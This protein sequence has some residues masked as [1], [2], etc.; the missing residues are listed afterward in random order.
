PS[1]LGTKLERQQDRERRAAG[2]ALAFDG[3]AVLRNERLREREPEP[4]PAFAPG[5]ERIEDAVADRIRDARSVVLDQQC[6]RQPMSPPRERHVTRD[7]GDDPDPRIGSR[8]R[9]RLRGVAD[10]I[11]HGLLQL[12]RIGI[13]FRKAGVEIEM[14]RDV[15]KLRLHDAFDAHEDLVD[16]RAPIRRQPMGG[17]EPVDER[18]QAIGLAYDHLRVLDQWRPVELAFEQLRR[19]ANAAQR[20][21]DLVREAPDELAVGLL[22]LLQALLA[23]DLQLLVDV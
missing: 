1:C 15:R 11:E 2:S 12:L 20:V 5:Y 3:P 17:E 9:E 6:K 7:A 21:L 4:G 23:R 19:A 22:L 16:V 8:A 10:D 18:L 13:E 14:K